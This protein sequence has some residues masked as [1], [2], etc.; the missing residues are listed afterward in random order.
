V[1][2]LVFV[3][4]Y[5]FLDA[6]ERLSDLVDATASRDEMLLTRS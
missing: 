1:G 3:L 5:V 6:F 2:Q 4:G